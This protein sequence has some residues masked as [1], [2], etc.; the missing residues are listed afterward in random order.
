[1][2]ASSSRNSQYAIIEA[3]PALLVAD[4]DYDD[5]DAASSYVSSSASLNSS[6]LRYRIE[7]GRTYHAYKDGMYLAPNDHPEQERLELQ[8]TLCVLTFDDLYLCPAGKTPEHPV[9]RVLD[10]GTGTGCWALEFAHQFPEAQVTGVDLSPIQSPSVPPNVQFIIDD[11]EDP[12]TY[13]EKFNFIYARFLTACIVDWPKLFQQCY[14]NLEPGGWLEVVDVLPPTSDDGTMTKETALGRW[15]DLLVE[16][17]KKFGRPLD[18]PL[19]YRNGM[20][21]AGFK[22]VIEERYMWPQN[23]WPKDTKLKELGQWS[24]ENI[25]SGLEAIS[26]AIFTRFHGWTKEDLDAFLIEVRE[27]MKNTEIHSYWPVVVFY[28]Q[29]PSE[30]GN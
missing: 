24:Y 5:S 2:A 22:E 27:D 29:K 12:W 16:G 20:E 28:A 19:T 1:M 21:H 9:D 26:N 14:D 6:I 30:E 11:A 17:T 25:D 13:A 18:A 15:V 4:S 23:Q 7:N 8:H 3:D 10:L